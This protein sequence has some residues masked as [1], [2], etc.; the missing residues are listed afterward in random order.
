L[1]VLLLVGLLL[2]IC[3]FAARFSGRLAA[4]SLV[5]LLLDSLFV[6]LLDLCSFG[7]ISAHLAARSLLVLLII[8]ISGYLVARSLLVMLLDLC[9]SCF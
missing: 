1:L 9:L 2:D 8:Y 3:F 7:L 5:V 4:R 6:L